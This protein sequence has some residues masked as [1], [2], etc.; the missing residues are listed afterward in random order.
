MP[1]APAADLDEVE[2]V[3]RVRGG[4]EIGDGK[5]ARGRQRASGQGGAFEKR[6][7]VQGGLHI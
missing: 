7:T 3:A 2:F 4:E 6:A 5:Q 1:A